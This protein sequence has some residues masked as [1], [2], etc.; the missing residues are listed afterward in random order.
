MAMPVN[1]CNKGNALHSRP[2]KD[3]VPTGDYGDLWGDPDD[4]SDEAFFERLKAARAYLTGLIAHYD[5]EVG[6]RRQRK[7]RCPQP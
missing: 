6:S 1:N 2:P 5:A 4:D 7:R 3:Y